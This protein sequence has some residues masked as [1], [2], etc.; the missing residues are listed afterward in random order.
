MNTDEKTHT[1]NIN[2]PFQCD[3]ST[4]AADGIINSSV[5][6]DAGSRL[7]NHRPESACQSS[8]GNVCKQEHVWVQGACFIS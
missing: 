7:A 1:Y 8:R 3:M 2:R 6:V 4:A 5:H